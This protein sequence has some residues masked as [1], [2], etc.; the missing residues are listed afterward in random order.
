MVAKSIHLFFYRPPSTF[1]NQKVVTFFFCILQVDSIWKPKGFGAEDFCIAPFVRIWWP[2]GFGGVNF[3][4]APDCWWT[5]DGPDCQ[6]ECPVPPHTSLSPK[7][8]ECLVCTTSPWCTPL[9]MFSWWTPFRSA[10]NAVVAWC[11]RQWGHSHS[12]VEPRWA[13]DEWLRR[14]VRGATCQFLIFLFS[15]PAS[16]LYSQP[17]NFVFLQPKKFLFSL[18]FLDRIFATFFCEGPIANLPIA[19]LHSAQGPWTGSGTW[20]YPKQFS[21]L[22]PPFVKNWNCKVS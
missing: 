10:R 22:A 5:K 12:N 18:I 16:F 1:V 15:Q 19:L 2:K 17:A 9:Q 8:P 20:I 6:Q 7:S 21:N 3:W 4:A 14:R 13:G 11:R